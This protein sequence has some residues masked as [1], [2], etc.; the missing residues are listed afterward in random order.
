MIRAR[1]RAQRREVDAGELVERGPLGGDRQQAL[2][3]V[4]AVQVD[5]VAGQLGQVG[6]R[7][8]PAV[9]VG[10]R[11]AV[12]GDHPRQHDLVG[13]VGVDDE[14]PVDAGL[15]SRPVRTIAGV[16]AAADQQVDRLDE[17]RLAGAGLAGQRGHPGVEHEH[18][19]SITPRFSMCSSVSTLAPS[20]S[21]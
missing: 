19:R 6:H 8:R 21:W 18:G 1:G 5:H 2:V 11:P 7:G 13:A 12:G 16:G 4:L 15:G 14:A 9:D 17:H 3:G 10:P 20:R